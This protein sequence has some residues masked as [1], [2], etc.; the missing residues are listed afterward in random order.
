MKL[1][2]FINYKKNKRNH[3]VSFDVKK[4]KLCEYDLDVEDLLD[5]DISK[6]K[7]LRRFI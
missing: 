5:L 7:N 6:K 2:D 1:R 4:R 3:Q